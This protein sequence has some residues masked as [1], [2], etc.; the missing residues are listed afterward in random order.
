MPMTYF[1]L[2]GYDELMP[3]LSSDVTG[4]VDSKDIP[5]NIS[6]DIQQQSKLIRV[7]NKDLLTMYL[8]MLAELAEKQDDYNN[9]L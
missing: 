6:R 2:D 7:I 1:S 5:M 9:F 4:T 3:M 8:K